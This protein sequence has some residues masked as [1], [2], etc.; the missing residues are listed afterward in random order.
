MSTAPSKRTRPRRLPKRVDHDRR[1]IEAILDEAQVAHLG[2]TIDGWPRVI[3]MLHA[4]LGD[5][6]CLHGSAASQTLRALASGVPACLTVT[7]IDGF[8]LARSAFHHSVNYRSAMIFGQATP[9]SDLEERRA[10]L[11]VLVEKLIP[12]RS[13]EIRA[14]TERELRATSVLTMPLTEASA[15]IRTGPPADDPDD[16]AL[17]TWAGVIPLALRAG[18]PVADPRLTAGIP[19]SPVVTEWVR[20][21]A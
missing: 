2:I 10:A 3:P 13:A 12:G 4:R 17:P 8:V 9:I 1:T 21:H 7:M 14:P 11:E 18:P 16:Y 5:L 20:R 6:V 19:P 15:K